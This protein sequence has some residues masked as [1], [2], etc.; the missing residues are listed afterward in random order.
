VQPTVERLDEL[1]MQYR[2]DLATHPST[3][4]SARNFAAI[5]ILIIT[6]FIPIEYYVFPT[7][8]KSFLLLRL[9]IDVGLI[10][11]YFWGSRL[12]P[13]SSVIVLQA[14]IGA[15][16]VAMVALDGGIT[17]L[18][19]SGLVLAF[20]AFPVEARLSVAGISATIVPGLAAF[21]ALPLYTK[22]VDFQ[23]YF[24]HSIFP[25]AGAIVGI[26]STAVLEG[27]RFSEFCRI[28]ELEEARDH[29]RALDAAKSRF[30]ANVHHELR[31]PLTLIISPIEAM[32]SGG[33]EKLPR[34]VVDHLESMHSN[35]LRLLKL[36]NNLLDLAKLE[37][38]QM[39]LHRQ[40]LHVERLLSD[41]L[42]GARPA[43]DRKRIRLEQ[44]LQL[45]DATINADR[46]ALEKILVNLLGN[47]L[48]FTDP[49]G[50]I[51]I[52]A[53]SA[54]GQFHFVVSDTGI[55]IPASHLKRV[56]DR[57]AQV[58]A[59]ATRRYEGTGIGLSLVRE[60]TELHGG[61]VWAESDGPGCGARMH[62]VLPIGTADEEEE[63]ALIEGD[64]GKPVSIERA[65][66]AFKSESDAQPAQDGSVRAELEGHVRR[67]EQE[68]QTADPESRSVELP[69]DA[70]DVLV[71][72][73]N[74]DMR[75][76]LRMLLSGEFR[77]QTAR[78]GREALRLLESWQPDVVL[79]D[80]MM[81]EMTG[82][83]LCR[84]IKSDPRTSR[85]PMLLVTSKADREMRV[86]GLELGADDYV[87]K[88]FH[89][90]ELLA[91]VRSFARLSR[92]QTMLGARNAELESALRELGEAQ[93]QLVHRAKM[94]SL[95]QLVAGI[96]HE[97]NNPVGF[98]QGN[99]HFLEDYTRQLISALEA[100]EAAAQTDA[101]VRSRLEAVRKE[102][103]LD[104]IIAD[105]DSVVLAIREGVQRTLQIVADLRTFSRLDRSEILNVNLHEALDCTLNLLRGRLKEIEVV[106][107][108]GDIPIV[109]C[110]GGQ[111]NQVFMNL[112]TNA[113]DAVKDRA[114]RIVIRTGSVTNERVFVDVQDNGVGIPPEHLEHIFDPFFTTKDVGE[115]TGL[116]LSIS[117]GVIARH[118]GT[119]H[120][121]S[122]PGEGTCFRIEIP[123][124]SEVSEAPGDPDEKPSA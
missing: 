102:R 35:G 73:D 22:G 62:V 6:S 82:L 103:R 51:R 123:I 59:S 19:A 46:D 119:I 84:T 106:R 97:I 32:L 78:N 121:A 12:H 1:R 89:P 122:Q 120:V 50:T 69:A 76:L 114:G 108:F 61:R 42:R 7:L 56:F 99:L 25:L 38:Q 116:G 33:L 40:P 20:C 107:E 26:A 113:A 49:D 34:A 57:F 13:M 24:V 118:G 17:S 77:V 68:Q 36:I 110:L 80:V 16:V 93:A 48:K 15:M 88:P 115:G 65:F 86:E 67:W 3:K 74:A 11:V 30:T 29:L 83:E 41:I 75:R 64:D 4:A 96:A 109:S 111:L 8:F 124:H 98:I 44:E 37:S 47:A 55:G 104:A 90:R 100:C 52:R 54:G 92:L 81:P 60:L 117:Y 28:L 14:S 43:A 66:Q 39:A 70:P 23:T 112:L 101:E 45:E 18:Y 105:V 71:V 53:E 87:T 95:G 10:Y 91:R 2:R 27:V 9:L 63:E 94:S 85:V 31:T 79:S 21:L 58:D 5:S 72:E